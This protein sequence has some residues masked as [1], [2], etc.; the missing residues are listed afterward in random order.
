MFDYKQRP[1]TEDYRRNYDRIWGGT[2]AVRQGAAIKDFIGDRMTAALAELEVIIATDMAQQVVN[3][4]CGFSPE[5]YGL[6][7]H[8]PN[9]CPILPEGGHQ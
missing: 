7:T 3:S 5:Y 1:A 6:P 2:D 9:G 8:Y 4:G